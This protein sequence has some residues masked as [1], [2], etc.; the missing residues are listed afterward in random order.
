ME[1]FGRLA[2]GVA[3]DFNNLLTVIT[4]YTDIVLDGL[5]AEDPRH[6]YL[7]QVARASE[8]A[9]SLTSQLLAFSRQ[10]VLQPR[11]LDLNAILDETGKM[12]RRIIGEDVALEI[13][14]GEEI[15]F[16]K[17][18]QS[19]IENVLVN[20]AANARDA[21][22]GGGTLTLRTFNIQTIPHDAQLM[23]ELEPGE[24][25][26]LAISDT[27][28]GM[29]EETKH[30]IFEPFFT[31]KEIGRG[32][33]L[34]LA[35]CYG[36]IAQSGGAIT[37]ESELGHGTTFTILLPLCEEGQEESAP[38]FEHKTIPGGKETLLVVEDE[39]GVRTLALSVLGGLGYR[40][41]EAPD[42]AQALEIVEGLNSDKL[43][44]VITDVV[45]P[46]MSGTDLAFWIHALR[47]DTRFLFI[48]GYPNHQLDALDS[49][50]SRHDFLRKP[51]S[52]KELAHKV[53]AMLDQ[54]TASS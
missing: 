12:L 26:A 15:G 20:M 28:L 50:K 23:T 53:R 2:G 25:V 42:G 27:G 8:R 14:A 43:D 41:L 31:T 40:L 7:Q 11:V 16:I 30:R 48:S 19:Q 35:T 37:V 54:P 3:H 17:A 22:P 47:P 33:G 13:R 5:T 10:Q 6:E 4:G 24:Y 51:F 36:I 18:D 32:T 34:G 52:P 38:F 9:A 29:S 49:L 44:L 1:A 39:P 45:M 21:M 46:K